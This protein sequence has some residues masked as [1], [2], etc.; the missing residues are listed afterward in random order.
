[1]FETLELHH[2]INYTITGETKT[3]ENLKIHQ[4]DQGYAYFFMESYFS[5]SMLSFFVNR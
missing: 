1:M 4:N 5:G 3:S 2:I